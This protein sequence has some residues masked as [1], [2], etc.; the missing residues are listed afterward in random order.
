[1][2]RWGVNDEHSKNSTSE[3]ACKIPFVADSTLAEREF[4]FGFNGEDLESS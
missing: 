1:M 3:D 2:K 4:E